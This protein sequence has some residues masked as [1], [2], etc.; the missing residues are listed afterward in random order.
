MIETKNFKECE[1]FLMLFLAFK[2]V[3]TLTMSPVTTSISENRPSF[4]LSSSAKE[5]LKFQPTQYVSFYD[6]YETDQKYPSQEVK[7]RV[8]LL[9]SA[10]WSGP[11]FELFDSLLTN[12]PVMEVLLKMVQD[13]LPRNVWLIGLISHAR[14]MGNTKALK[15]FEERKITPQEIESLLVRPINY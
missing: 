7:Q 8:R 13:P 2:S 9:R 6:Y 3:S 1:F 14:S 12:E 5:I 11:H 15:F 10:L 4:E